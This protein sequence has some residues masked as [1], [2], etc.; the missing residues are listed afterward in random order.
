MRVRRYRLLLAVFLALA[1]LAAPRG[2]RADIHAV[3]IGVDA[4]E[5]LPKLNGAA[6][7]ARDLAA[8]LE[9]LGA[10]VELIV[11][12][13]ATRARVLDAFRRQAGRAGP[14]DLFVF[15]Y[16]G[17]GLQEKEAIAGDEAD[18]LDETIVFAGFDWAAERAGERLRD[19]EIGELLATIDPEARTLIVIDSCHSGTMTRAADPRGRN[20]TTRFGGFGRI[21]KDPL[22]KPDPASKGKDVDAAANFVYVAAARDDEQ[23]PEVEIDGQMRGA[24]SW[25]VARALDGGQDFGG[26]EMPLS[27]FRAFVR[28]Q[29]R[30]LAAARQTPSV[31]LARSVPLTGSVIPPSAMR[32]PAAARQAERR[33][34]EGPAK[35]YAIG[36][37]TGG[38]LGSA[39]RF[40]ET[41][42]T[43]DLVWDVAAGE[44]IDRSGADLVAEAFDTGELGRALSKWRA[45]R[46]LTAWALRRH[47][48][49]RIEPDDGRHRIGET[50]GLSVARPAVTPAYLTLVNLASSGETQFVFP[51]A[52]NRAQGLDKIQPGEGY[53]W[54]GEV[55]V[56]HPV[57]ADH[58]V[59]IYSPERLETLHAWLERGDGDAEAF[60][61][62]LRAE[63]ATKGYSVGVTP[64]FTQR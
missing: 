38:D 54:L 23:I 43:A 31:T 4:Y 13:D 11:D 14:G 18:G 55:R 47:V 39:G 30:A 57:G 20:V 28:A 46:M 52:A 29:A 19:N 41:R 7:D 40:V 34:P 56:S 3:V 63:A 2:A 22:P 5:R 58:V 10:E 53:E 25:T 21:S 44:V 48:E 61:A 45:A 26:P 51:D 37:A 36:G 17:H 15:T 24:V 64:I 9:R 32:A 6:N 33:L 62:L 27:E 49:F 1:A 60:V 42:E 8:A 16:A 12:R 59:A 50:I 35:V